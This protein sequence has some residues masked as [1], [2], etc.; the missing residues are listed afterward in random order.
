MKK[1]HM[2]SAASAILFVMVAGQTLASPNAEDARDLFDR[3][4][5]DQD[6]RITRDEM[7]AF[8]DDR[9]TALDTDGDGF[10]TAAEL[11]AAAAERA[12]MRSARLIERR[13]TDGDG[14]LSL[15]EMAGGGRAETR[16]DRVDTDG[17]GVITQAEFDAARDSRK[18]RGP[19][20]N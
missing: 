6:G 3:L 8:R 4:D 11:E 9:L 18:R 1:S 13:D 17:D 20:R 5:A 19:A 14:K 16:F 15:E 2:C 10:I 7:R 12:K